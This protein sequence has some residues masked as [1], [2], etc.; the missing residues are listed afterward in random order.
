MSGHLGERLTALVDGELG[1]HEREKAHRHLAACA[2]CR[3]EAEALRCLKKRLRALNDTM[4]SEGLLRRLEAMGEPGDPLPPPV[5]RLPGQARSPAVA[6]P[7]DVPART[8]PSDNR[9]RR[10]AAARR[11]LP[12]GRY[13]IAGAA[14]LAVLGVGSAAFAAGS[15]PGSLPRVTPSVEQ[16]AVEHALTSGDVPLTDPRP[17]VTAGDHP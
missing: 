12:R 8:R 10:A 1:H 3:A 9:P 17:E 4:P 2:E 15:D 14:T 16:F 5:P 13:L 6:R 11:R 7:G